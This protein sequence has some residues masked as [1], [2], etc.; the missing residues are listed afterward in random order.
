VNGRG[1]NRSIP[2]HPPL[3]D[4]ANA[5]RFVLTK[6]LLGRVGAMKKCT[7]AGK[8]ALFQ[9]TVAGALDRD[10]GD[11]RDLHRLYRSIGSDPGLKLSARKPENQC[12]VMGRDHGQQPGR[13]GSGPAGVCCSGRADPGRTCSGSRSQGGDSHDGTWGLTPRH[14]YCENRTSGPSTAS[15]GED[16]MPTLPATLKGQGE[17]RARQCGWR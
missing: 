5:S 6:L 8:Q 12:P 17:A 4:P 15:G 3:G 13:A 14:V 2:R 7:Q 1:L 11:P 9:T 10:R 16:H